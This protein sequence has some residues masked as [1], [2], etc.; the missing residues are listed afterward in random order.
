M[1]RNQHVVPSSKGGW[2]VK[3]AGSSRATKHTR[4]KAEAVKIAR[5]ISRHQGS[6]LVIHGRNGKI[7]SKDS[8]G[9]DPFPP[10]G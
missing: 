5:S 3:A 2:N 1:S 7:Q 8:H 9:R 4:T 6:E 10:R